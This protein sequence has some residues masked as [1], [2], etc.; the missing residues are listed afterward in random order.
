MNYPLPIRILQLANRSFRR[1]IITVGLISLAI[2][3]TLFTA[4]GTLFPEQT[5]PGYESSLELTG[6]FLVFTLLPPYL[7]GCLVA[8]VR[9]TPG[10]VDALSSQV[11]PGQ[12]QLLERLDRVDYWY[13]GLLAGLVNGLVANVPWLIL[14]FDPGDPVFVF[15]L[16]MIFAQCFTWSL[17]G[18]LLVVALHN[19]LVFYRVG[20]VVDIDLF[21]LDRL[22]PFGQSA[23]RSMLIV[24]GALA[25]TPLQA[26]DQEFRWIN[27]QN[28]V[29]VGVPAGILLMLLPIWSVHRRIRCHKRQA[30]QRV[31]VEIHSTPRDL[32]DASLTRL[33]AL[34]ER[35]SHI[36][37]C[38]NWPLDLSLFTRIV[39]YVLIPPLA[40]AGAALVELALDSYLSG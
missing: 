28:A 6:Q 35:R 12:R 14:S 2:L 3:F 24:V 7:L 26:L 1:P 34:L 20:K 4:T 25:I 30:M 21:D 17:V 38:R 16:A 40:W 9:A 33:N 32:D 13:T 37:H 15:S 29:L 18:L 23:L 27:Y 11:D 31:D 8:Q 19:A 36:A 5:P 39:I 10:I 22:N